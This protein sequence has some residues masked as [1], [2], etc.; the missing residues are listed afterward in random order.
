MDDRQHLRPAVM[1]AEPTPSHLAWLDRVIADCGTRAAWLRREYAEVVRRRRAAEHER[2]LVLA[3]IARRDAKRVEELAARLAREAEESARAVPT[4]PAV[5]PVPVEEPVAGAEVFDAEPEPGDAEPEPVSPETSIVSVQNILLVLGGILLGVA[6][7]TFAVVA[8][9]TFGQGG[10]A[11]ILGGFTA[12]ALAVPVVLARRGLT[13]TA[14]TISAL[15]ILLVALD[16]YTAWALGLF[17]VDRL[18]PGAAYAGAVMLLTSLVATGYRGVT[19]LAVPRYVALLA[20]QPVLVLLAFGLADALSD[21]SH[22][23]KELDLTALGAGFA[24]AAAVAVA[25][26][27]QNLVAARRLRA[28]RHGRL[29]A[30]A[31]LRGLAWLLHAVALV[32]AW[33]LAA[34]ALVLA[35]TLDHGVL[36]A[37]VLLLCAATGVATAAASGRAALRETAAGAAT[38]AA[39]A[40]LARVW[41]LATPRA[42]AVAVAAAVAVVGVAAAVATRRVPAGW[43]RGPLVA[44]A[45]VVSLLS[46]VV[47]PLALLV[48]VAAIGAALPPW[49]G[50]LRSVDVIPSGGWQLP[51]VIVLLTIATAAIGAPRGAEPAI[52]TGAALTV[53]VTPVALGLPW[54]VP[55]VASGA[56][57]AALGLASVWPGVPAWRTYS[58]ALAAAGLA[59]YAILT[60][61]GRDWTSLV[62][63]A[64]MS[65]ACVT[66][67]AL[68]HASGRAPAARIA[69]GAV[70][71]VLALL[72]TL[73]AAGAAV[74]GAP[75][76]VVPALAVLA[77]AGC[78]IAAGI[79][80]PL[81]A[82]APARFSAGIG[83]LVAGAIGCL[84]LAWSVTDLALAVLV[85]LAGALALRGGARTAQV[86]L[87]TAVA[88]LVT[89]RLAALAVPGSGIAVAGLL[90]AWVA[91]GTTGIA[92]GRDA[93]LGAYGVGALL[94]AVC[95]AIAVAEGGV[96][97]L[98]AIQPAPWSA[99]SSIWREMAGTTAV[100]GAQVPVALVL[101]GGGA[102]ALP[103]RWRDPLVLAAGMLAVL[104]VPVALG[105]PWW[106]PAVLSCLA[107]T[108]LALGAVRAATP[109]G[110]AYQVA[111]SGVMF[112]HALGAAAGRA[113]MTAAVFAGVVAVGAV[114]AA[115][116]H[117]RA[118]RAHGEAAG[119]GHSA[120]VGDAGLAAAF[121][122][123]PGTVGATAYLAGLPAAAVVA[124]GLTTA[125]AALAGGSLVRLLRRVEAPAVGAAIGALGTALVVLLTMPD[126]PFEHVAIWVVLIAAVLRLLPGQPAARN[127][128][129]ATLALIVALSRLVAVLVPGAGLV[130]TAAVVLLVAVGVRALPA[131]VRPGPA[132]ATVA[133]L[134]LVGLAGAAQSIVDAG[135][136]LAVS[137]P[138]WHA[139]LA[140]WPSSG[141]LFGWQGPVALLLVAVAAVVQ[142][143]SPAPPLWSG[144]V[145][146]DVALGAAVLAA[147]GV[148]VAMR[149]PWWGAAAIAGA[150][151]VATGLTAAR[152][153]TRR[154]AGRHGT[155]ALVTALYAA[156]AALATPGATLAVAAGLGIAAVLVAAS[157]RT[158]VSTVVG[159]LAA[160][161][162]VVATPVAVAAATAVLGG[163]GPLVPRLAMV[164]ILGSLGAI[165]WLGPAI[166]PYAVGGLAV[167]ATGLAV[168]TVP[169]TE[170]TR[171]YAALAALAG[172][173][174]ALLLPRAARGPQLARTAV[175]SQLHS[176]TAA[177]V[178]AAAAP[179]AI[180]FACVLP[181]LSTALLA[182]YRWLG[183]GWGI[184][185]ATA[186][187]AAFGWPAA[188]EDPA[189]LALLGAA[190]ALAAIGLGRRD[191]APPLAW[192]SA[193]LAVLVAPV[194]W[195][196]P[197]PAGPATAIAVASAAGIWAARQAPPRTA[198]ERFGVAAAVAGC[199]AAAGAGL[200]ASLATAS[201]TIT[202]LGVAVAAGAVAALAGR[203]TGGRVAGWLVAALAA[204]ALSAAVTAATHLPARVT[205]AGWVVLALLLLLAAAAL[206]ATRRADVDAVEALSYLAAGGALALA[207]VTAD[208]A[209]MSAI[210]AAYGAVLGL[211]ASRPG[212]RWLAVVAAG[213]EL[214][215]WWLLLFAA[216]VGIIE[217]YTLPFAL[218]AVCGGLLVLRR[219]PRLR[220]WLAYGPALAAMFLPSLA[221]LFGGDADP[222][223]RLLLGAGGVLVLVFGAA[224]RRQAPVV[225]G[226]LVLA[227]VAFYELAR[228]WDELPRWLPMGIGG[229]ILIGLG[230]TY[231]R[232]RRDLRRI[233]EALGQMR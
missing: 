76:R 198:A 16:G 231:E 116:G 185:P 101:L 29:P 109:A 119:L 226:A 53:A 220:S 147:V 177:P 40:A 93:A 12:I 4:V 125:S 205:G 135:R 223:R 39:A 120:W 161:A 212:R 60:G 95:G 157:A 214:F 77:A 25:V 13:A 209:G 97:W 199:A 213:C 59:L 65:L 10:R 206:P 184:Q 182:P 111:A 224:R 211:S 146:G 110:A 79:D 21:S 144:P 123:L 136:V 15:A 160:A 227:I 22:R 41:W 166:R 31:P 156:G 6:A 154:A 48:A 115:L 11:L 195:N 87:A 57:A 42:G 139:D 219:R 20:A 56:L 163:A 24:G 49:H 46:T 134:A 30:P 62:A 83:A 216:E 155:A 124:A 173:G 106:S 131:R 137:L 70:G 66:V 17:G 175:A 190:A 118:R 94:G 148:P 203:R 28:R 38:V 86:A 174:A 26:S 228:Y 196:A 167:A 162:A 176:P 165:R 89:A 14:E 85:G 233:G 34:S 200:S 27:W 64:A 222:T 98:A 102:I 172:V 180:G 100:A 208:V 215:A 113:A 150:V 103:R 71:G 149:A 164:A 58:R 47:V 105:L 188:P 50:S 23:P 18:L 142:R 170:P 68:G 8:W 69:D 99:D 43:R 96:A 121:A 141:S 191:W 193:A 2:E 36:A 187:D 9:T 151:A 210:L 178:R 51:L 92:R 181:T 207:A 1:S 158:E 171:L 152:A 159:G 72:P 35:A 197:W 33:L 37:A 73:V 5:P 122:A 143:G 232:R 201:A 52:L 80:A 169:G 179:F 82:G 112:L 67:A 88:I 104:A 221:L 217:A 61:L 90:G 138:A 186:R 145:A 168:L 45:T 3:A 126:N 189:V 129:G 74:A 44:H 202:A 84:G 183:R 218:F 54:W 132:A 19:R 133:S 130:T 114:V 230:A 55:P 107:A 7:I 127:A 192:L 63:L 78:L 204:M 32:V 108:A 117:A 140:G 153:D 75:A 229:L 81:A 91:M 128:G 225:V 194:A